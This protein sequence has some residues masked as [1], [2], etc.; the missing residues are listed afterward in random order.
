MSPEE[1]QKLKQLQNQYFKGNDIVCGL[2]ALS[3]IIAIFYHPFVFVAIAFFI[4]MVVI[5]QRGLKRGMR[6]GVINSE[7]KWVDFPDVNLFYNPEEAPKREREN[8][9]RMAEFGHWSE[10]IKEGKWPVLSFHGFNQKPIYWQEDKVT[11]Y[12]PTTGYVWASSRF[13]RVSTGASQ[14]VRTLSKINVG[15]LQVTP[16]GL[17]FKSDF[18]FYTITWNQ[19][20][21]YEL[22]TKYPKGLRL[23]LRNGEAIVLKMRAKRHEELFNLLPFLQNELPKWQLYSDNL[24]SLLVRPDLADKLLTE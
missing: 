21:Q 4:A 5:Y 10:L 7:G 20:V 2:L 14:R 22:S 24:G 1:K 8:L 3:I 6:D 19:I 12:A 11:V 16:D 13:G 9:L 23:Y 15:T 18:G 17:F